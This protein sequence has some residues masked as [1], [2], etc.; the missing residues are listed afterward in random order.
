MEQ[1]PFWHPLP[2]DVSG[3]PEAP[4]G[5]PFPGTKNLGALAGWFASKLGLMVR[6]T[7]THN[8]STMISYRHTPYGL[9]LRLHRMFLQAGPSEMEALVAFIGGDGKHAGKLLDRFMTE[10]AAQLPLRLPARQDT[11]GQH[12]DL[13]GI[14]T[15]LNDRYFHG[16]CRATVGWTSPIKVAKGKRSRTPPAAA[17]LCSYE[18]RHKRI[19]IDRRLDQSWV[20]QT[21]IAWVVYQAML[22]ELFAIGTGPGRKRGYPLEFDIVATSYAD[23]AACQAWEQEHLRHVLHGPAGLPRDRGA[24]RL[25]RPPA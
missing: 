20:P 11:R 7:F 22:H 23:Y 8:Y 3:P 21:Y 12:H 24:R 17:A 18:L 19:G 16:A 2:P 4:D 13:A 5:A 15:M 1:L 14:F 6:L 9:R 10:Q 25:P